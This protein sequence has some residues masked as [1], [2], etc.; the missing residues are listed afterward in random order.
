MN[1]PSA[2]SSAAIASESCGIWYSGIPNGVRG[3]SGLASGSATTHAWNAVANG[4]G[5]VRSR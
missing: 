2:R 1:N 4:S 5:N 3:T